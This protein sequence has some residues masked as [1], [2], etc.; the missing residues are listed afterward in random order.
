MRFSLSLSFVIFIL[1]VMVFQMMIY[2]S[3]E[4]SILKF[5]IHTYAFLEYR[6]FFSAFVLNVTNET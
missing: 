2:W 4:Q 5:F 3:F 6:D 1:I